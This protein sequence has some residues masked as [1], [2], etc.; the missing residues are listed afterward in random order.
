MTTTQKP[1]T[2][3]GLARI[4]NKAAR[5]FKIGTGNSANICILP[6]GRIKVVTI[7][8]GGDNVPYANRLHNAV[9]QRLL[10]YLKTGWGKVQPDWHSCGTVSSYIN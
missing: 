7:A 10:I 6:C 5:E 3:L 4:A 9:I 2:K 1:P 8:C